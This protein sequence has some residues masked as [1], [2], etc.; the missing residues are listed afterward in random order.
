ML[1]RVDLAE[2]AEKYLE[3]FSASLKKDGIV[4][5]CSRKCDVPE[6]INQTNYL[7]I[8]KRKSLCE[9]TTRPAAR[10]YSCQLPKSRSSG[11][12]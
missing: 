10:S 3:D 8:G 1:D 4:L 6:Q 12:Q 7:E 5:F 9:H 2:A 11:A